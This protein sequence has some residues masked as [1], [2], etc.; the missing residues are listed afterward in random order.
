MQ[1]PSNLSLPFFAYGVF[2]PGQLAFHRLQE[3]VEEIRPQSVIRGALKLRDGLPIIDPSVQSE[4]YGDVLIFKSELQAEAYQR[5]IEL[6]P[7]KHYRWD[8]T[9]SNGAAVN[10]LFGKS[11]NKGSVD[12][13]GTQWDGRNDPL[14]TSALEVVEETLK[15]NAEFEW[16]LKPLFRLQMAYLLL[17]SSIER[18]VSLKYHLGRDVT[19]KVSFLADEEAFVHAL[20]QT[21]SAGRTVFRADDPKEK[22]TLDASNPK[23][24]LCYYY[25]IRSNITHRGKAVVRDHDRLKDSLSELLSIFRD[26]LSKGF[27]NSV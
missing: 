22:Y 20:Q 5:I 17:W 25:Q 24:S 18:Y 19:R 26:V 6:E 14:F 13:E 10:V 9:S 23:E 1:L 21:V 11:P 7:D 15:A 3:L 4:V 27:D 12:F 8:V 2:R 16:D